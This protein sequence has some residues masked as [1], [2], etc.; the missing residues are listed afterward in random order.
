[1]QD[2]KSLNFL[3]TVP[4]YIVFFCA[5]FVQI[6]F[7]NTANFYYYNLSGRE[8]CNSGIAPCFTGFF[9]MLLIN[10]VGFVACLLII[11]LYL[12]KTNTTRKW[13]IFIMGSISLFVTRLLFGYLDESLTILWVPLS[14]LIAF[15]TNYLIFTKLPTN[16]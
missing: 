8:N 14:Y 12:T 5:G 13:L 2:N 11:Y 10:I 3:Y 16:K 6:I 15:G 1:M 9:E 4:A 7:N